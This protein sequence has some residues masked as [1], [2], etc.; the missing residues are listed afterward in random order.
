VGF[1]HGY[2]DEL[3]SVG[4]MAE[5]RGK[6]GYCGVKWGEMGGHWGITARTGTRR[7][8]QISNQTSKGGEPMMAAPKRTF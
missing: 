1:L 8:F 6:W 2:V 5:C 7:D 3:W 4:G